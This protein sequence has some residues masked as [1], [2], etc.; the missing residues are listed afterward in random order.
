M[1][2]LEFCVLGSGS[3]GNCSLL[4]LG[5]KRWVMI[6]AGFSM[7]QTKERMKTHS[8][9]LDMVSDLLL[10]HLD[11]D[12]FNPAWCRTLK[13]RGIRVHVHLHHV[14]RARS[15][16]IAEECIVPFDGRVDLRGVDVETVSVAHD[17]LGTIG[18]I[19]D[20]NSVRIGYA[21]DLGH[22]P[23]KLLERFVNLDAVIIESNYDPM[24]QRM[25][26]RPQSLKD[27]IMSGDGHLSNEQSLAAIKHIEAESRL[28]HIILIHL[29]QQ[30]N[31]PS[32]IRSLYQNNLPHLLHSLTITCQD[33]CSRLLLIKKQPVTAVTQLT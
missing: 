18:F 32:I 26:P 13:Q 5:S 16:G 21:T 9:T 22:V 2:H 24:M 4:H 3:S 23:T 27:R 14:A 8:I 17:V 6:D 1:S 25:S 7:K 31:A 10:T 30:C 15:A 12:H 28:Q 29:S 11:R 20:I 19:F 33:R